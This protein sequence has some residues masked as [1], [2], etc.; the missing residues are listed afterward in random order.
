M[1]LIAR[2]LMKVIL[3]YLALIRPN[4]FK[5]FKVQKLMKYLAPHLMPELNPLEEKI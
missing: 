3:I 2:I 4:S 1:R 5:L